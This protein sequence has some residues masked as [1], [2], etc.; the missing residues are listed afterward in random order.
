MI[1]TRKQKSSYVRTEDDLKRLDPVVLTDK[2]ELTE[3]DKE[4]LRLPDRFA[5]SPEKVG[6][7][8]NLKF[9]CC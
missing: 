2:V 7:G 4:V 1:R 5:P 6:L 9:C 3:V 8:N